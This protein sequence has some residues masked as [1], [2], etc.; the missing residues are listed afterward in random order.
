MRIV[1]LRGLGFGGRIPGL[2]GERGR[3]EV[4][5]RVKAEVRVGVEAEVR[6]EARRVRVMS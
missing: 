1:G 6:V 3:V 4:E 2:G 5:V